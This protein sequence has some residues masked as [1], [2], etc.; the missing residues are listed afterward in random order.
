MDNKD[1]ERWKRTNVFE[2]PTQYHNVVIARY[3]SFTGLYRKDGDEMRLWRCVSDEATHD[4][5]SVLT[6]RK[7]LPVNIVEGKGVSAQW[8]CNEMHRIPTKYNVHNR[9]HMRYL[10]SLLGGAHRA[11][12]EKIRYGT[13]PHPLTA[14]AG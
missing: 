1:F 12:A 5:K 14:S 2:V 13:P 3:G 6:P 10:D 11:V 8:G 7:V 9:E 4:K